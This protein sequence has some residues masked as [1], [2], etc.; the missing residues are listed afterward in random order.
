MQPKRTIPKDGEIFG[1]EKFAD[2]VTDPIVRDGYIIRSWKKDG[3][4]DVLLDVEYEYGMFT[5]E[6][7]ANTDQ[8]I[9]V[10]LTET[11]EHFAKR[12]K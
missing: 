4:Y 2:E 9:T 7:V 3:G 8:P 1:M 5:V 10:T 12:R 6:P 11:P